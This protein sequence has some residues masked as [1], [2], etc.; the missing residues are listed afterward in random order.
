VRALSVLGAAVLLCVVGCESH[1]H[2]PAQDPRPAES[3][4]HFSPRTELFIEFP[5]L[6]VG[7]ESPFAAHVTRL[8]SF[9]PLLAGDVTVVLSGGNAPE[10]R[11]VASGAS[12]PGIFRPVATPAHAGRRDLSILIKGEG[13][14]DRHDLG[15]VDVFA[16]LGEASQGKEPEEEEGPAITFLKE[17]QWRVPFATEPVGE[18]TL[19]PSIRAHGVIRPRSDGEARITAPVTGRLVTGPGEFPTI[20]MTVAPETV[21]AVIAPR[22]STNTDP[23]ELARAVERARRDLDLARRERVRLEALYRTE[24]VPERRVLSARHDEKDAEADLEAAEHRLRQDEG[25]HRG[26]EGEPAGRISVRSPIS[27]TL[28]QVRVAPGEF[29]D[30]GRELFDVLDLERL[31]LE[32]RI[33]EADVARTSSATGAWFEVEGFPHSFEVTPSEG[34]KIVTLG[35][36]VDPESRTSALIFELGNPQRAL[37]A[38][39][40]ADV[41]VLTGEETRAIAI[42]TSAIVD[43]GGQSVAYVELSGESFERRP[44]SLGIREQNF[45]QVL[46]GL[47]AGERVVTRGAYYVRL[48]SASGAVPAHGHAH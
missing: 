47:A 9:K 17:Q 11:F 38:G 20:G 7:G 33:P 25:I 10:E 1:E 12:S 42:P 2:G 6:V 31:W 37:R 44:L 13:I 24:A 40:F 23:A 19:R 26:A 29:V 41:H 16:N 45:V 34:G 18:R 14:D 39:M 43:E 36:V 5:A 3:I 22:L 48:A 21:L 4:T 8:D 35:G 28:V 46:E 30:E 27:G 32:V 15:P